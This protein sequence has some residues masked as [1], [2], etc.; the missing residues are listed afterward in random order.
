MIVVT[1]ATGRLGG[2]TVERLL[3][4]RPASEV[5]VSVRSPEKAT[6]LA[7]RGVQVRAGDYTDPESM[8]RSLE[9]ARTVLLVSASVFG[10]NVEA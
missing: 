4:Q 2:L 6:A 8:T 10:I 5:G 3:A 7:E 1:G 9:G